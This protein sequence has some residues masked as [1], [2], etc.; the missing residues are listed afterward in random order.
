MANEPTTDFYDPDD[1]LHEAIASFEEAVDAGRHPDPQEWLRRYPEV[2]NRL[3]DYFAARKG[4]KALATPLLPPVAGADPVPEI[5]DYQILEVIG[6]GGM[7]VVYKAR[8]R[9]TDSIVALKVIRADRLE[10]LPAEQRRKTVERFIAE[11]QAAAQLEHDHLVKVYQVGEWQGRPFYTMRYVEGSSLADLIKGGPLEARRAAAYL[12][13]VA[14]GVHEAHQHGILHRDLKPPNIL[15]DARTDR[16]LVADFGLAKLLQAGEERTHS[17]EVMGTPPYMSPEQAQSAARVTVVSDVY[18]LGATLYALLTGRPPFR[19]DTPMETLRKVIEEEPLPPRRVQP[20]VPRDL[21]TICLKCL[22]KEPGKRY[23]SAEALADDLARWRVGEEI[24]ARPLRTL[25]RAVKWVRRRPAVSALLA[26]LVLAIA[27]GTATTYAQYLDALDQADV[28]RDETRKKE[29]ALQQAH[30]AEREAT[31]QT[32]DAKEKKRQAEQALQRETAAKNDAFQ[33]EQWALRELHRARS[34][35][36]T[37]QLLRVAAVYEQDPLHGQQLLEDTRA[38]PL[39]LRDFAWGLYDRWCRRVRFAVDGAHMAL[40]A[41]GQTLA[42]CPELGG[43]VR[44]WDPFTGRKR[45][46]FNVGHWLRCLALTPDG[47]ILATGEW[48]IAKSRSP[49]TEVGPIRLWDV[50]TGRCRATLQEHNGGVGALAFTTDG[51]LLAAAIEGKP[52]VGKPG[53]PSPEIIL[54]DVGSGQPRSTLRG[55]SAPIHALAFSPDGKRLAS[56]S[57]DATVKLWDVTAGKEMASLPGHSDIVQSVAFSAD[58]KTLASPSSDGSVKLWTVATGQERASLPLRAWAVAFAPDGQ[59][60]AVAGDGGLHL[61]DAVTGQQGGVLPDPRWRAHALAFSQDGRTLAIATGH[62]TRVLDGL[63]AQAPRV[64][65]EHSAPATAV[66]FTPDG[67]VLASG[68]QDHT[69]RLWDAVT[70]QGRAILRGHKGAVSSVAFDKGGRTLASASYDQTVKLWDVAAGTELATFRGHAGKIHSIAFCEHNQVWASAGEDH[71]IKLWNAATGKALA[72]LRGHAEAVYAVVFSRDGKLLASASDDGTVKLWDALT[73]KERYTLRGHVG[74]VLAVAFSPD[75]DNLASASG[76]QGEQGRWYGEV[77]LWDIGTGM[78]RTTFRGHGSFVTALAFS[79]DGRDLASGSED[80]IVKLWDAVTGQERA[81][82]KGAAGAVAGLAFRPDG[83]M[84]AAA[85]G[86]KTEQGRR[87]GEVRLWEVSIG[88]DEATLKK[89]SGPVFCLGFHSDGKSLVSA[90]GKPLLE[91]KSWDVRTGEAQISF[92]HPVSAVSATLSA[93]G[94]ILATLAEDH[95]IKLWRPATGQLY[96]T[97]KGPSD[98][99]T[100]LASSPDGNTLA[101]GTKYHEPTKGKIR[102]GLWLWDVGTRTQRLSLKLDKGVGCLAF[103][104]DGKILAAGT[105]ADYHALADIRFWD[106]ASG[107]EQGSLG[108][109]VSALRALAFSADGRTL[110]SVCPWDSQGERWPILWD[111]AARARI[112]SLRTSSTAFTAVAIRGDGKMLAFG[113][114]LGR[115]ILWDVAAERE[116]GPFF[117]H[118]EAVT[119]L[120]FSPSGAILASASLDSTIRLW[121]LRSTASG[122]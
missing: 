28:A 98:E 9:S 55:H 48:R 117:R 86:G 34:G 51:T 118:S 87:F 63:L 105:I 88:P 12:E 39:D 92:N 69:I 108:A 26:A 64:L 27:G 111:V 43:L 93:D 122:E 29:G 46:A 6:P 79:P 24:E 33:K 21:E 114:D 103:S 58:G 97:L 66:A 113:D 16:P 4:V 62:I 8:Q 5:P 116:L 14:R 53:F 1:R 17:N 10:G 77:K 11:A 54:V 67:R 32:L 82:L 31:K 19:A 56:G 22:D 91:L 109:P 84:L 106:V 45:K 30:K 100:C 80:Q 115:I 70:G 107:S 25:G 44:L 110:A 89:H 90:G 71:T 52:A 35:L 40:S 20:T 60:L 75:G 42:T 94:R 37:S 85:A 61:C 7:G 38:C 59:T 81:T 68:S 57:M 95:T 72:T 41:N 76:G 23:R 120:A 15:V 96:G 3:A 47:A 65:T 104:P 101:A 99:I 36:L 13:Q 119:S 2:A 102:G 78:A 18:S 73:G 112:G 121:N 50:P 49:R 74:P 83:R